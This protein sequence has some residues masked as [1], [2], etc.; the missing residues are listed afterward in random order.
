VSAR[1]STAPAMAMLLRGKLDN[2]L[3][4]RT[5]IMAG[6]FSNCES[7]PAH[8]LHDTIY[9]AS[10]ARHSSHGTRHTCSACRMRRGFGCRG[11]VGM[12]AAIVFF[13]LPG[14][15]KPTPPQT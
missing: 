15:K 12:L 2:K 8:T 9:A 13:S 14:E 5:R 7:K 3:H 11:A 1:A 6:N 10:V 4:N